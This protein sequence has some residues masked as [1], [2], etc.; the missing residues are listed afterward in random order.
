MGLEFLEIIEI[1]NKIDI[2]CDV[3]YGFDICGK[4]ISYALSI[5]KKIPTISDEILERVQKIKTPMHIVIISSKFNGV[6]E[7]IKE[8]R[9][10]GATINLIIFIGKLERERKE[11][12]KMYGINTIVL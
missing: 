8:M 5:L 9:K 12:L 3:F 2:G 6:I 7:K 4:T 11:K 10:K 1:C